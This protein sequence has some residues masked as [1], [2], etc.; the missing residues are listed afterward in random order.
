VAGF[1]RVAS[2]GLFLTALRASAP[3]SGSGA[4]SSPPTSTTSTSTPLEVKIVNSMAGFG[5]EAWNSLLNA[6]SSPFLEYD[7]LHALEASGCA[8]AEEGWQPVHVGVYS[9]GDGEGALLVAACPLY[10]KSHSQGEFI[11]DHSWADYSERALGTRYYPKLLSAVPF[12]PATGSR[13]LVHPSL[14]TEGES[15]GGGEGAGFDAV[16]RSVA[17]VLKQIVR[18][19]GLSSGT[20]RRIL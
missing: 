18:D 2:R 15:E 10:V 20:S 19:N 17:G 16:A 5:R 8:S 3:S 9:G 11:F 14:A 1:K 4:S 6:K 7:W 12:T 13:L